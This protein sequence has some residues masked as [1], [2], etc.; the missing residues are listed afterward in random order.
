MSTACPTGRISM[1]Y[2]IPVIA[3]LIAVAFALN[4]VISYRRLRQFK[5]PFWCS[6]SS[7]WLAKVT[8]AGAVHVNTEEVI[9]KYGINSNETYMSLT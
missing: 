9:S 8:L 5:G 7:F 4:S 2:I 1:S 3:S 6:I